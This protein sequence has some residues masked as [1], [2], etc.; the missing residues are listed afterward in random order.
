MIDYFHVY[1][2][3]DAIVV[4]QAAEIERLKKL[5]VIRTC[6]ECTACTADKKRHFCAYMSRGAPYD[7]VDPQEAPPSWCVLRGR[8]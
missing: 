3:S 6:N 4:A 7:D 8:S 1:R 2:A 5:P